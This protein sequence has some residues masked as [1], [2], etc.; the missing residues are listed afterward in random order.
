M[1]F[2]QKQTKIMLV[3]RKCLGFPRGLFIH[4]KQWPPRLPVKCDLYNNEHIVGALSNFSIMTFLMTLSVVDPET[5]C[6]RVWILV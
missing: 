4:I 2:V 1:L 6:A 5:P 3:W